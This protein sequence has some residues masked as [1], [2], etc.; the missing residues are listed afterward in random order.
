MTVTALGLVA[1]LALAAAFTR[2]MQAA[3]YG[4][5]PL[6]PVSFAAAPLALAVV[7][8]LACTLP[9]RRAAATDPAIALRRE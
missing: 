2:L 8:F 7:A 6:D 9:A 5:A 4:V 3:L 1:G